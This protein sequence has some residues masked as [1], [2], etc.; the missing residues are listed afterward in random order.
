MIFV[1]KILLCRYTLS[2]QETAVH[3][4]SLK[5][6]TYGA[7]ITPLEKDF[8]L[9]M[10][11]ASGDFGHKVDILDFISNDNIPLQANGDKSAILQEISDYSAAP[12][13]NK[14]TRKQLRDHYSRSAVMQVAQPD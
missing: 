12:F 4:Y 6:I 1:M 11:H 5:T 3:R 9:L 13:I 10:M 7:D 14:F 8:L 2:N